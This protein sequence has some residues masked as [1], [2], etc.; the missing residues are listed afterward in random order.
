M[1][2]IKTFV[3]SYFEK[4][5]CIADKCPDTCCVGWEVDIDDETAEKY[6]FLKGALGEKIKKHFTV[7][8][9]GC[10]IFTL[11]ENDR[12]PFLNE[13]KLCEIYMGAGESY[14]SKTC[15]LFPRFFDEFGLFC[16]MGLGFGCPE[17]AKI[18]LEDEEKFML[19]LLEE[20]EETAEEKDEDFLE[21][22]LN[23]R[24]E[25]FRI[26][27]DEKI[28]IRTR[29]ADV[30]NIAGDFQKDVDGE[31]FSDEKKEKSIDDCFRI[32][33]RMEY[34]N[35]ERKEFIKEIRNRKPVSDPFEKYGKDFEKLMK[36][37][38][39]RYLLKALYDYDVLTKIKYGVFAVIVIGR[40]YSAFSE[41]TFE[42]R[43]KIMYSF[44]KE[45]EYSDLN[46]DLL[47]SELFENFGRDDLLS[48]I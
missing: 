23:L 30:L 35:P 24:T 44:S 5:R 29:I 15:T 25:F 28:N 43:T 20:N 1:V 27:E 2:K 10:N 26:L 13:K 41:L 11:C 21:E 47:D 37:Y 32:L 17:A 3:P 46:M 48:L 18:I 16:E 31:F 34:I 40:I 22:I 39:F 14:L 45:V 19:K 6:S 38:I 8:E 33:E 9:E 36:Y 12:C 7:D 4:F 42:E